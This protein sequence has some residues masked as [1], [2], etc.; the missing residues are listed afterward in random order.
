MNWKLKTLL[1]FLEWTCLPLI[2]AHNS[3]LQGERGLAGFDG[4]PGSTGSA[5]KYESGVRF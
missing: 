1:N 3:K 5:G 2:L 4:K